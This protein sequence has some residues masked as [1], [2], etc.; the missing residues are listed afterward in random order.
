MRGNRIFLFLS[1][2]IS[3]LLFL[4][5]AYE[6]TYRIKWFIFPASSFAYLFFIVRK[7]GW[8]KFGYFHLLFFLFFLFSFISLFNSYSPAKTIEGLLTLFSFFAFSLAFFNEE[9]KE[10]LFKY[11]LICVSVLLFGGYIQ[12]FFHITGIKELPKD[13]YGA[14]MI[15]FAVGHRNPFSHIIA[16]TIP[17]IFF[18]IPF[19]YS[20]L[21]SLFF[22]GIAF[23]SGSRAGIF[24]SLFSLT[25]TVFSYKSIKKFVPLL[26]F[27][28][29]L[30][31]T[32]PFKSALKKTLDPSYEP[33]RIRL[34][35]WK[36]SFEILKKH[37]FSGCGL[38]SFP[39]AFPFF[40]SDETSFLVSSKYQEQFVENAHNDIISNFAETGIFG[41]LTFLAIVGWGFFLI[42]KNKDGIS[43]FLLITFLTIFLIS[44]ID[45]P[46]R[47]P[48]TLFFAIAMVTFS[49][50]KVLLRI[51]LNPSLPLLLGVLL[52]II[53]VSSL[54][55]RI[56]VTSLY[57]KFLKNPNPYSAQASVEKA[58]KFLFDP[59]FYKGYYYMGNFYALKGDM[60][61][62]ERY[63]KKSLN[64]FKGN[65]VVLYNL[66]EVKMKN[67]EFD[68]A[69]RILLELLKISPYHLKANEMI[70]IILRA[71]GKT[72][73]AKFYEERMKRIKG[74]R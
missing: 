66:S 62:A 7:E 44:L 32:P 38:S 63:Y 12:W 49:E 65:F 58:K 73:E 16:S 55:L 57:M 67:G 23:L 31:L 74:R 52:G 2:F 22:T 40:W 11:I 47:N 8:V 18:Y 69:K 15:N 10:I 3:I 20:L 6:F 46:L 34:L 17:L 19:P 35:L 42:L 4:P 5:S 71:E 53:G 1:V 26:P 39:S 13:A 59:I 33:N 61:N 29:L 54:F 64:L 24:G 41:G 48:A 25:L 51:K 14:S 27:L 36:D 45:Y 9:K 43:R 68:S 50:S 60:K 28:F 72:K 37:P 30:L 21:C 56:K 70:S